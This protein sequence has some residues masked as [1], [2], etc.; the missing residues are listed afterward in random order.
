MAQRPNTA[1]FLVRAWWEDG[2]FRARISYYVD[3]HADE[4]RIV[5]DDPADVRRHLGTWLDESTTASSS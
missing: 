1:V 2:Q 3:I 5:T 4:T